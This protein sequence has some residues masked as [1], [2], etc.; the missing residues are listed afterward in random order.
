MPYS[1][2]DDKKSSSDLNR[3]YKDND[4]IVFYYWNDC[5]HCRMFSPIF[6]KVIQMLEQD[7]SDFMKRAN[8]FK[9]EL[10][11]FD[12]L[13]ERLKKIRLFP[14]VIKYSNGIKMDEFNK[15]RTDEN[16]KDY[17]MESLGESSKTYNSSSSSSRPNTSTR[18]RRI[19]RYSLPKSV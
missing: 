4:C 13:P 2:I 7:E 3:I 16:L 18:I 14:S 17:I 15:A 6:Q 19:K 5:P 11:N 1:I 12:Y 10:E 8:I 9:V